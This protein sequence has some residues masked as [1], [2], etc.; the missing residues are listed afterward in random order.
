MK[1][2]VPGAIATAV[3]V[4]AALAYLAAGGYGYA[5]GSIAL[6]LTMSGLVWHRSRRLAAESALLDHVSAELIAAREIEDIWAR[7]ATTLGRFLQAS[8]VVVYCRD[9]RDVY[10]L[11]K[12]YSADHVRPF[13][14]GA[15]LSA[16][17]F[18]MGSRSGR[19]CTL[20]CVGAADG[21]RIALAVY[22]ANAARV[23]FIDRFAQHVNRIAEVVGHCQSESRL[24][25]ARSGLLRYAHALASAHES[26]TVL[27]LAVSAGPT[28]AGGERG[29][30]FVESASVGWRTAF[31][32]GFGAELTPAFLSRLLSRLDEAVGRRGPLRLDEPDAALLVVPMFHGREL[33]GVLLLGRAGSSPVWDDADFEAAKILGQLT[34]TALKNARQLEA[35][36]TV[37][38]GQGEIADRSFDLHVTLDESGTIRGCNAQASRAFGSSPPDL[39]GRRFEDLVD[40]DFVHRWRQLQRELFRKGSLSQISTKLRTDDEN[41]IEVV[42]NA[43]APSAEEARL[44]M[45][46]VTELRRLENQLRHSQR[47]EVLGLLASGVAHD[48]NNVLGGVLGYASLARHQTQD[49]RVTKY[50]ET[51]ERTAMRGAS[52]TGRLLSSSRK[53]SPRH[54]PVSLNQLIGETLELLAHS[55]PKSIR[56][57][58][59]LDPSVRVIMADSAQLQQILLNLAINARDAM[60]DGGIMRLSTRLE[61]VDARVRISVQDTGVGMD[62]KVLERLYEPFFS[63]KGPKGTGL[64]LSVVYGIVKSLSGDIRVQSSPGRGTRFD[65]FLPCR[66]ADEAATACEVDEPVGHGELILLVD[67]EEVLRDLGKDILETH[68]YRVH[69]VSSGEEAVDF[70]QRAKESVALVVLDL[71]MPGIDGGETYRRLRHLDAGLPVLL[72]SGLTAEKSVEEILSDRAT[73]FLEKPYGQTE[74][75][76]A[77]RST[78]LRKGRSTVV[79]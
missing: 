65:V 64:G 61:T 76:R 45:S 75:A 16:S 28:L 56:I 62:S 78:I 17:P 41:D 11:W 10:R 55:M 14:V 51:I 32:K 49:P 74:L 37:I 46:N 57:E 66:W 58:T 67:D 5:L 77:V 29:A 22:P 70:I 23:D 34:A 72:S 50:V 27:D 43:F 9:E 2:R 30:V 71:V 21:K 4:A 39:V 12:Q 20:V 25:E 68:G 18:E 33:M 59:S 24:A 63:T 1:H 60:R 36:S 7:A 15:S 38:A 3:L 19:V 31:E 79:H 69:V 26:E 53:S 52:L 48:L 40:R 42:V 44:V 8:R 54:E 47:Q 13:D 6:A 73:A 35:L